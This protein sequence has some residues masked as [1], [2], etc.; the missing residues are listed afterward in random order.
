MGRIAFSPVKINDM[1]CMW[2]ALGPIA[3]SPELQRRG[4][5]KGLV[6]AGLKAIRSLGAEGCVLVGD[7]AYYERFGFRNEPGLAMEGVPPQYLFCPPMGEK[8]PRGN[9]THHPA[10]FVRE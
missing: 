7:P 3:V 10:F 1:D 5:G 4:I 8:I 6:E 9:V 2:L